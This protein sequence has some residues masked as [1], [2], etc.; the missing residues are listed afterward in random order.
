MTWEFIK[1]LVM[2][3]FQKQYERMNISSQRI[4]IR[5]KKGIYAMDTILKSFVRTKGA[6]RK[7][8]STFLLSQ[9]TTIYPLTVYL[10]AT[11]EIGE[12]R[13]PLVRA[14]GR[15]REFADRMVFSNKV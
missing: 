8:H 3:K 7:F 12:K 15:V 4:M 14:K 2:L 5:T 6:R 1:I 13:A 10:S 11:Y 9:S